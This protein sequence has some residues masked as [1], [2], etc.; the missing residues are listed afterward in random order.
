MKKMTK[1]I[2]A[3][4]IMA[5]TTAMPAMAVNKK[6]IGHDNK[7]KVVV[8]MN[9]KAMPRPH[10]D[11]HHRHAYHPDMRVCAFRISHHDS[12]HHAVAKAERIHGVIDAHW[13]PRTHEVV[14]R[15]NARH[16]TARHIMHIMASH[17]HP[18]R[19]S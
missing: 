18:G 13:N 5:I 12:P 2:A 9:D 16:T 17:H 19:F 14:V 8:V 6:H 7:T 11:R 3:M 10:F 4:M 15:Y 1:V